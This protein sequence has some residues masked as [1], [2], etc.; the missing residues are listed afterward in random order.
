MYNKIKEFHTFVNEEEID[1]VFMSE[2]WEREEQTLHDIIKLKD[3]E[4]ISNVYQRKG[5][6]GRPAI[7]VNKNKF[8]VQN[9]TNT[10]IN[11]KWGVEVVWCLLTPKNVSTDSKIQK[12]ACATIYCKPNSKHKSDLIDHM[13]EA[14]NILSTKYQRGLHFLIAGDTND[15]NLT[16]ILNLS[17]NLLQI[18]K[19]PTRI[20]PVTC[21]EAILDPIITSLGAYYQTAQCLPPLDPDPESNGKPSD[22]MIVVIRPI[23]SINNKNSRSLRKIQVRPITQSGMNQMGSWIK[24]QN[25]GEIYQAE[26]SHEKAQLL[27]TLLVQKLE[28]FFP[29]KTRTISSDDQPWITHKLK[30][31]DR[32]RKREYHKHRRS[33]K[34]VKLNKSFKDSVKVAKKDFYKKM[35]SDIMSK[36]T[37]QWYSSI[38]RMTSHDQQK[39]EKLVVQEIN[40]L[41]EE[42]QARKLSEH[43]SKIP[44]EF[45][46]LNKDDINILP[47]KPQDIPQFEPVQVW[48][49]LTQLKSNKSTVSGDISV[50]IFKEFAAH[51]AEPLAHVFNTSLIQGE[52]PRIYKMEIT[53]PVPKKYPVLKMD[54]LRNISGLLTADKIFEMLLAEIIISD[55]KKNLDVGQFGNQKEKSIQHYLIKMIHKILMATDNNS[56]RDIFAVIATMIDWDS[57]FVRQCPK[58]GVQAFQKNGVRNSII[59][60][61]CS[62]FQERHQSIKWRGV[63]TSRHWVC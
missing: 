3:H 50:R 56:R 7:I 39:Y 37:S 31:L 43:F 32:I 57:A 10:T 51:I 40:H 23:S 21:V 49:I 61:L 42:E 41:S 35:V 6:G 22:H 12:I 48:T 2:S 46:S 20:D 15:L 34:W 18:V 16:P 19:K 29:K 9:L 28:E 5:K 17:P 47:I 55:M 63:I 33:E 26:S 52:Y 60:L 44:N 45:N 30:S 25:W 24:N 1:L 11:I 13:A 8:I 53:T 62:Y 54:N 27:Q 59:P 4:I 38:K 14:Y 36:N 58:L